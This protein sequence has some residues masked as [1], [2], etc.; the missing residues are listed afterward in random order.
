MI[1]HDHFVKILNNQIM[2]MIGDHF[3]DHI[4]SKWYKR[5]DQKWSY[6]T[7]KVVLHIFFLS[8]KRDWNNMKSS[9]LGKAV[10]SAII[11]RSLIKNVI[12]NHSQSWS[13]QL[14]KCDVKLIMMVIWLE[15]IGDHDPLDL[16]RTREQIFSR[17]V[18]RSKKFF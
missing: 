8:E 16:A 18:W 10:W 7:R 2:I 5:T 17:G 13:P 14:G 9:G 3:A 11:S 12:Y 6:L 1:T 15:M 4:L